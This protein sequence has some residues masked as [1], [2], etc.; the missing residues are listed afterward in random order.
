MTD[1][2]DFWE[3]YPRQTGIGAARSQW[4]NEIMFKAAQPEQVVKAAKAYKEK[5]EDKGTDEQYI[6]KPV[7]FLRDQTYLDP[8]LN[9]AKPKKVE[10]QKS[11]MDFGG[12]W[13]AYKQYLAGLQN[14]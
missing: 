11:M 1:F 2:N 12:D 6:Q 3:I 9:R 13:G 4:H 14:G 10:G 7:T 8:E 5:M